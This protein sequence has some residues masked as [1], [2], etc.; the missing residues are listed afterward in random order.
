MME[1]GLS[2]FALSIIITYVLRHYNIKSV[3]TY[4]GKRLRDLSG[5]EIKKALKE[6]DK[7][8]KNRSQN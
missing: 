2:I 1:T 6:I 8:R 4:S 3:E 5:N 7:L